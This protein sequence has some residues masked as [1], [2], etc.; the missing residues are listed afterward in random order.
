MIV[1]NVKI[2]NLYRSLYYEDY[3]IMWKFEISKIY[4]AHC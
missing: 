2:D 1:L 3:N 4:D